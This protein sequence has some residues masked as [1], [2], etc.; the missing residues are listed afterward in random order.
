MGYDSVECGGGG[1][2]A[3]TLLLNWRNAGETKEAVQS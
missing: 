1:E 2:V 3:I